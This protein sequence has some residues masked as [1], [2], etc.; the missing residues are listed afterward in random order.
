MDFS[1][2]KAQNRQD[3]LSGFM[4][5]RNEAEF[6]AQSIESWLPLLDELVIVYN[7][8][9]DNTGEIAAKYAQR[10]P[11]KIKVFH[12]IPIVYPQGSE[13]YKKLASDDVHSLVHYYNFALNQTTKKWA[14]KIDGDLI[15]S[16]EKVPV[17]R[18]YYQ[19]L[20]QNYPND[21]LPVSGINL[22]D[23]HKQL[24]VSTSSPYC[25]LHGDL[26]LFR[27]DE[28][29]FFI[30]TTETEHL[31]LSKRHKRK[32]VFAYYHLKFMKNDFGVGNY[33]LK[34]NRHSVYLPKTIVFLMKLHLL[35]LQN[36]L[37]ETQMPDVDLA[38][39][40]LNRTRDYQKE[41][42]SYLEQQFDLFPLALLTAELDAYEQRMQ[43]QE[44]I[45]RKNK[46][47]QNRLKRQFKK[48]MNWKLK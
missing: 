22:I 30:K 40:G 19:D 48:W 27:V 46:R 43:Q 36:I 7:N 18:Q 29:S 39:F 47:W 13:Q 45:N 26:C 42:M 33:E 41:A 17:L 35:P 1:R 6:L 9:Q 10:F 23:H 8:C 11:E 14:I 38:Y 3:G 25:G 37:F 28:D 15:L 31:D 21:V 32:N 16:S 5:L 12:Y 2:L 20:S 44:Y 34:Q 24:F 4:R